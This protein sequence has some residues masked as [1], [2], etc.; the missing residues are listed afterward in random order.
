MKN[1]VEQNLTQY[2]KKQKLMEGQGKNVKNA[3]NNHLSNKYSDDIQVLLMKVIFSHDIIEVTKENSIKIENP[4]GKDSTYL[5]SDDE[6]DEYPSESDDEENP[7]LLNDTYI[8]ACISARITWGL[9]HPD[10][11]EIDND[12][13]QTKRIRWSK[14]E[15]DYLLDLVEK[16]AKKGT[17]NLLLRCLNHIL[18]DVKAT[19]I[20]HIRHILSTEERLHFIWHI[21]SN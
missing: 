9:K 3:N 5:P 11:Y 10:Y 12:D 18:N 21:R 13:G 19:P 16:K 20:F 15:K 4:T 6:D 14:D 17:S 8:I 2:L 7:Y 1:S